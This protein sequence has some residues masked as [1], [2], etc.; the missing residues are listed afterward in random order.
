MDGIARP[1]RRVAVLSLGTNPLRREVDRFE[2]V[3]FAW[4]LVL[5]LIGAPLL[6]LVAGWWEH[7]VAAATQRAQQSVHL[8]TAVLL[9]DVP[10]IATGEGTFDAGALARWTADGK[11]RIGLVLDTAGA[12]AG[13]TLQI[14]VDGS[15]R[16]TGIPPLTHRGVQTR[17][18]TAAALTAAA[19]AITMLIAAMCLRWLVNRRRL[20]GWGAAWADIGPRWTGHG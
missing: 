4:L 14:W 1:R 6:A 18:I 13:S 19:F 15:G 9:Q 5:F 7:G 8:V 20:A 11:S 17:V 3:M 16:P 12:K 2:A 10:D